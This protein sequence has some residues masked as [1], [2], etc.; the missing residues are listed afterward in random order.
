MI[1]KNSFNYVNKF[2]F[3]INNKTRNLYLNSNIYNRRI[4]KIND[5]NLEYRPNLSLLDCLIKYEKKKIKIEDFSLNSIWTSKNIKEKDYKK[6]HSFFWLFSLDLKSSKQLVQSTI[7]NWINSNNKYNSK[8][9]N[10]DILSKRIIAWIS[11]SKLTY[12]N[13]NTNYKEQFNGIIQKQINHLINEIKRSEWIDDKMTGCAA[14]ILTGISYQDKSRYLNFGLNLLKKISKFSFDNEGFPRSRNLRQLNFYL[15]YFILIREWLKESQNDIP[16]YIDENIYHLGQSYSLLF[17]N[18]KKNILFNGNHEANND[19]FNN[20][21]TRLGYKFKN[22]NHEAGGYL[23]LKNKK[24]SLI[25]DVG[26]SPEKKFSNNY[27]AGALSFEILL[28][29]KKLICNSGYFQNHKHQLHEVSKSTVAHSTL[30]IDNHSSCK[31]R[32]QTNQ[33]SAIERGLKITRKSIVFEKN[34]W[35]IGSAHDGYVKKYGVVHDRQIEF[36]PEHNKFIGIDKLAKNKNFKSSNFEIRFHLEP[37]VKIMKTQD[38]KSIFIKLDNEGWKFACTDHKVDME[39][40]LYFGKK[41]SYT[42]NQN[43]FI[44]GM[45]QNENQTIKWELIKIA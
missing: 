8:N 38:G 32:K 15:K 34:Y 7:L 21:L 40:G 19:G 41:N 14:I 1:F 36:F 44:S 33:H 43:I 17:Q 10:I 6:L 30:I 26:P 11:N 39:T 22:E 42:E 13:S 2:F 24:I 9:W 27:Q 12:E 18:I 35:C 3:F 29:D 28:G 16:D 23:V 20:Y 4:S 31:L 45:T 25:M 5:K 37:N